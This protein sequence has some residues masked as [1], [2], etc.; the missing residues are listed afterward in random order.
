MK[1]TLTLKGVEARDVYEE[2]IG[3]M[4]VNSYYLRES[5]EPVMIVG[6]SLKRMQARRLALKQT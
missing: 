4:A 6:R 3:S 5:V 1:D 2:V